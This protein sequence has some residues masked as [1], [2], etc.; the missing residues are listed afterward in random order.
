[1][2]EAAAANAAAKASLAKLCDTLI[3]R[4]FFFTIFDE[5]KGATDYARWRKDLTSCMRTVGSGFHESL[6]FNGSVPEATTMNDA[7][8]MLDTAAGHTQ[9]T[10][11]QMRQQAMLMV[12]RATLSA[13]G[14]SMRLIAD[15]VHAGGVVQR[16]GVN[17]DQ[18]LTLL[19][20]RWHSTAALA[21]DTGK[22]S[23]LLLA[24]GESWPSEFSVDAFNNHFNLALSRASKC[25][26]NPSDD[27]QASIRLRL[28]WWPSIAEPPMDSPYF[29][30]AQEARAVTSQQNT[31]VAHRAAWQSAMIKSITTY[32][33]AGVGKP[34]G[35]VSRGQVSARFGGLAPLPH[36]V[37]AYAAAPRPFADGG[38]SDGPPRNK[39][40][41]RCPLLQDGTPTLHDR[42]FKCPSLADCTSCGS[43]K[44]LAHACWIVHGIPAGAKISAGFHD[45]LT[46][47]RALYL[48]GKF[49]WMTTPT[50]LRW[51]DQAR[52]KK[53]AASTSVAA[54]FA[55]M[56]DD[57]MAAEMAYAE[58]CGFQPL[59]SAAASALLPAA[60]ADH[61]ISLWLTCRPQG[62][63]VTPSMPGT[64]PAV[65][66][67][68]RSA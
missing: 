8:I 24:M 10:M 34:V 33:K 40:C 16:A 13:G 67:G 44:H 49:D 15:C 22:E 32:A 42:S 12:M 68:H 58:S 20:Q 11:P 39:E 30:A 37:S 46:R 56:C 25:H 48:A 38:R 3:T 1:M 36:E 59:P 7:D 62:G 43:N 65:A 52:L 19:D 31:T 45:E 61:P 14:E 64:S 63:C 35:G 17:H 27:G 29:T 66:D 18:A 51:M 2:A 55:D 5:S 4:S 6:L 57:D 47:L 41:P 50:T 60:P 28:L 54:S 26:L 9:L 21:V 53:G 23:K